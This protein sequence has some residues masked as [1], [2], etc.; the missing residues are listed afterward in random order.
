MPVRCLLPLAPV[1]TLALFILSPVRAQ[2]GAVNTA[3]VVTNVSAQD[4]SFL[5][6]GDTSY[7]FTVEYTDGSGIDVS[8]IGPSISGGPLSDVT[9]T[10]PSG[11]LAIVSGTESSG[12]DGSPKTASYTITPPGSS[13][14]AGDVG[15]YTIGIV[16]SEV[17]DDGSPQLF[18]AANFALATFDV[19][20]VTLTPTPTATP[21]VTL[22]PTPTATPTVTPTPT[23]TTTPTPTVT[24]TATPMPMLGACC[25]GSDCVIESEA[26][27]A[28]LGGSY[29]GDGTLCDPGLCAPPALNHFQCYDVGRQRFDRLTV[30]L[31]DDFS[32]SAVEVRRPKLLCAPVDKNAEDPNAPTDL[33]HLV[34]YEIRR[35]GPRFVRFT[36]EVVEDQFGTLLLDLRRPERILVPSAKSLTDPATS[37]ALPVVDHY[38]CYSVRGD[39]RRV[40]GVT[41]EDQFGTGVTDVK[42]PLRLCVPVDKDGE[43]ILDNAARLMCYQIKPGPRVNQTVFIDNQFG[44]ASLNVRRAREL[45]VP[46]ATPTSTGG[47]V[48]GV[49]WNDLNGNGARDSDEPGLAGVTIY[50]DTNLN[51]SFDADEPHAITMEDPSGAGHYWIEDVEPGF[52]L[53]REVV[54]DGFEQTFPPVLLCEATFCTGR[55][56]IINLELGDVIE[57]LDF[58]NR[59]ACPCVELWENGSGAPPFSTLIPGLEPCVAFG[60]GGLPSM[61]AATPPPIGEPNTRYSLA[62]GSG[63][64]GPF[65]RCNDS[66]VLI[67]GTTD[68]GPIFYPFEQANV[69]ACRA[70][71]EAAGCV[72]Q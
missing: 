51:G 27:C 38:Q 29:Q 35:D 20:P 66:D 55:A 17:G 43:G 47:S 68:T 6:F 34:G 24:S 71:V 49:K 21:T 12:I 58:G 64:S 52:Y 16:G 70:Y 42:K 65:H 72:F 31:D 9:V 30:S 61:T 23:G 3:P 28:G 39:R 50:L 44:A 14:D 32:S 56:H 63:S 37:L 60:G 54:P 19:L 53:V 18:V 8:T 33:D 45:C 2:A 4:V 22:T 67:G 26:G 13:W 41:V 10:G 11:G 62:T 57:G 5:N 46:V 15:T 40:A 69:E 36:D 25:A 1:L 7:T 48:H 59:S